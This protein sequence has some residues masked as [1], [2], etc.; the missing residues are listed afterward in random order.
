MDWSEGALF[1]ILCLCDFF[2]CKRYFALYEKKEYHKF[3]WGF[4]YMCGTAHDV[5]SA[6]RLA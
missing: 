3:V 6:T 5:D 2:I 1:R 4:F